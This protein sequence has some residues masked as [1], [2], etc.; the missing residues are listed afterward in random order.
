MT[1]AQRR[2]AT[3]SLLYAELHGLPAILIHVGDAEVILDDS[4]R[5]GARSR[6]RG[7]CHPGGLGR[8]AAAS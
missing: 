3:A 6:G 7:G 2:A 5:F 4:N 1:V 8:D